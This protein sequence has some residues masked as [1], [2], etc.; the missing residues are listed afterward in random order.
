MTTTTRGIV[1]VAVAGLAVAACTPPLPPDVLAAQAET[2]ITC[3]PGNLEVSVPEDFLGSMD[4]V[5]AG[6]TGVC[7]DQSITEFVDDPNATLRIVDTAPTPEEVAEFS[8][9]ACAGNPAIVVPAFAYAVA[10]SY[11]IIGLEG[12]VFTP[13]A[14]AGMLDGSVTSWEDPLI[15]EPNSDYDLTLLP[16][17]SVLSVEAPQGSVE[18]MTT[19]LTQEA[20]EAWP[21]GVTGTIETGTKFATQSE[22]IGE[23]TLTEGTVAVIPAFSA[24]NN[25]MPVA[26]VPVQD[27]VISPD[28]TQLLKVGA[29]AT[30]ITTD[31]A[32]NML[33]SPAIGGV[34]VEGNFDLASSKIVLAEGQPLVGWPIM[35]YAH[36]LVCDDPADPLALFTAQYVVR[37]A[38]QG[39]LETFGVTPMP[40]PIRIQTFTPLKVTASVTADG[41]SA[42]PAES[43][44]AVSAPAE[45]APAESPAS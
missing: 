34:P 5:G 22:L 10:M 25:G 40:E 32:G 20:P 7:P 15:T 39:A 38:G 17:V 2:N 37:L 9:T 16:P 23:L 19:W 42:V 29:G 6:L 3:Q 18:A 21:A 31:E 33:A 4:A 1:L 14:I 11:D 28:D 13:Q 35:G 36:M 43:A 24:V 27:L 44:P 45:S 30:T 12:I 41:D 26:S 8:A